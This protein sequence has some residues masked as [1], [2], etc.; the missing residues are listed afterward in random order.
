MPK[1]QIR[2]ALAAALLSLFALPALA[3]D[4]LTMNNGDVITGKV[5][6]MTDTT[7]TIEP[8]YASG[9]VEI[10]LDEVT[11][12]DMSEGDLLVTLDDGT[13]LP[14]RVA[15]DSTGRQVV[16]SPEGDSR[17]VTLEEIASMAPPTP[18][19]EWALKADFNATMNQGNTDSQNTLLFIDG[20]ARWGDH[21]HHADLT[22]R[23]E[24]TDDIRTKEQDLFNYSYN[25]MFNDPWYTGASFSY[26]RDPIRDLDYRYTAGVLFG[27]DIFNDDVKFLTFSIGAGYSEEEIGGVKDSGMVGLWDLRYTHVLTDGVDFFHNHGITQQFYGMDNLIFKSNTGVRLDLWQDLYATVSLRYDYE[28]EP[29][30]GSSKDDSTL[31]VGL[32]YTF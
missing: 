12:V 10:T 7:V 30:P 5:T 6:G 13:E 28:T 16:V 3:Q 11:S 2:V 26:E 14:G 27:R 15:T 25:W 19:F 8:S 4:R 17:A 18:W 1:F 29:A 32:G 20:G 21:R 9:P 24:E 22:F 23:R 31:A